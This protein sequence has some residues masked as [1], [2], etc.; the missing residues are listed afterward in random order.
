M[1]SIVIKIEHLS[2]EYRLGEVGTGQ[3][4]AD[5]GRWVARVRGKEDPMKR[6]DE[7]GVYGEVHK[8]LEDVSFEVCQGDVMGIVGK[9]GAGKSTLLK[10]L[11]RVTSPTSGRVMC[12]GRIASLLEVGTGFHQ[13]LTGRENVFLNAAILGMTRQEVKAKF[14]EIVEFSG[15]SKFIDTPVK[16]YSSGMFVRLAFAVA[17]HLE[18]EI[19]IVDEV[20]AVGDAEFQKK[21]LGKM[22]DVATKGRTV[23]FVSH[24]MGAVRTL[25]TKG[26]VLKKGNLI[27]NGNAEEAINMY[28]K[29][30]STDSSEAV[31]EY[32]L[33]P[34]LKAQVI[35]ARLL[36]SKN[37]PANEFDVFDSI[38]LEAEYVIN[39]DIE[40]MCVCIAVKKEDEVLFNTYDTDLSPELFEKRKAGTY[41]TRVTFQKPMKEGRYEIQLS[42]GR[43]TLGTIQLLDNIFTFYTENRSFD[44][45]FAS[46]SRPA[47]IAVQLPWELE[48]L[49]N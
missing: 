9:N 27:Y 21:C 12:R 30:N 45:T 39:Q 15:V 25:C 6:L 18:P 7:K 11:S 23:L 28:L 38:T 26:I 43:A 8:A 46:Y 24:N 34:G 2:K 14:D 1:S 16:R 22:K 33:E 31:K 48:D 36:N 17:A 3:L 37:E 32:K 19:L 42:I 35:R 40:G 13:D 4:S 47:K 29:F 20:L 5:I 44:P 10:I 49:G 41:K